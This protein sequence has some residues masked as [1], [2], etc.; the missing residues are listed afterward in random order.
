MVVLQYVY[1]QLNKSIDFLVENQVV[2]CKTVITL[3]VN[4]D[5]CIDASGMNTPSVSGSVKVH[6]N[7]L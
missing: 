5:I 7:A 6:W 1:V 2:K 3:S 4:V